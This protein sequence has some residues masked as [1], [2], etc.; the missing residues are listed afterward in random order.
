MTTQY[1]DDVTNRVIKDEDGA[2]AVN[3]PAFSFP[4]VRRDGEHLTLWVD[5]MHGNPTVEYAD[6]HLSEESRQKIA[7]VLAK[8]LGGSVVW[9][10]VDE[11]E[12]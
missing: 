1:I 8:E 5:D 10:T 11:D 3:Q 2:S 7:A 12:E 6:V 9:D 4:V